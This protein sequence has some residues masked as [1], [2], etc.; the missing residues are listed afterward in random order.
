MM[1]E[2]KLEAKGA[3]AKVQQGQRIK[4]DMLVTG[5]KTERDY[6]DTSPSSPGDKQK[7]PKMK[8]MVILVP[9]VS[10]DAETAAST[11]GEA[12]QGASEKAGGE[13][14]DD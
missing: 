8:N 2:I 7:K 14:I 1:D 5:V 13:K 6:S 11:I 4:L 9:M 10:D 12:V 3:L